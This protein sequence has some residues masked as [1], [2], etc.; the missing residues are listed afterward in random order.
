[1]YFRGLE[2]SAPSMQELKPQSLSIGIICA[3]K[4][5][6]FKAMVTA[7]AL[8]FVERDVGA[9]RCPTRAAGGA[10]WMGHLVPGD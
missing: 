7:G 6:P 8:E 1:M 10:A 9:Y 4:V 5:V 2:A 3:R